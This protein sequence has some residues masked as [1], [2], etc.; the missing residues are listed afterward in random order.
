VSVLVAAAIVIVVVLVAVRRM[1]SSRE[2]IEH[3]IRERG[4]PLHAV[5]IEFAASGASTARRDAIARMQAALD[6]APD[7]DSVLNGME[8]ELAVALEWRP[9]RESVPLLEEYRRVV[10]PDA[11]DGDDGNWVTRVA[12]GKQLEAPTERDVLTARVAAALVEPLLEPA[13][14]LC[15]AE[16]ETGAEGVRLPPPENVMLGLRLPEYIASVRMQVY[17][18]PALLIAGDHETAVQ[19]WRTAWRGAQRMHGVPSVFAFQAWYL[20]SDMALGGL[21]GV[22]FEAPAA[23]DVRD[24]EELLRS[25]DVQAAAVRAA[26][27][28]RAL[29]NDTFDYLLEGGQ[30]DAVMP[31]WWR[32]WQHHDRAT[33]LERMTEAIRLI[34][35]HR[36]GTAIAAEP[37]WDGL[38]PPTNWTIGTALIL[39][40]MSSVEEGRMLLEAKLRVARVV[41]VARHAGIDAAER[42]AR[43]LVDPCDGKPIRTRV[44]AGGLFEA[45]SIGADLRDDQGSEASGS[46]QSDDIVWRVRVA[47]R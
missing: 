44:G 7:V 9:L 30:E 31:W 34:R 3:A 16:P 32:L 5:E 27:G 11:A 23:L 38:P 47:P 46:K 18:L 19:R 13:T 45:W 17:T 1:S 35:E 20:C 33:Y 39:P 25:V 6:S 4:E 36:P 12:R 26:V 24:A 28:E 40:K 37:M 22:L 15:Q 8:A 41:L 14:T 2:Q 21:R 10:Q 43:E 42:R 29:G